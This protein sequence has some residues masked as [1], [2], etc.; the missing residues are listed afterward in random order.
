MDYAKGY[1]A[2]YR[3]MTVDAR[4]WRDVTRIGGV[5]EWKGTKS[6]SSKAAAIDAADLSLDAP[7]QGE[8]YVRTW[9]DAEQDGQVSRVALGT[10]L[11]QSSGGAQG[12]QWSSAELYGVLQPASDRMLPAGWYAPAGTHGPTKAAA[13]L[14]A[15]LDAPVSL[16]SGEG[17]ELAENVVSGGESYLSMAWAL[18]GDAWEIVTDGMGN[19][20]VRPKP[21][22]AAIIREA[23]I[24]GQVETTWKLAGVPNRVTAT[25][26]G[27]TA[28]AIN[29]D[30]DSPASTVARGRIIDG[31]A[32]GDRLSDE[33]LQ[34]F[35]RR[36][37]REQSTA[38]EIAEYTRE[39]RDGIG[40][41]DMVSLPGYE[42]TWRIVSQ[43]IG[44][45]CGA[46]VQETATREVS[47][48]AQ[49]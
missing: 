33:T 30:P 22:E 35:C 32:D 38:T 48:Y 46:T 5:S 8:G 1:A 14:A 11:L 23:D 28:E 49:G 41:G 34:A 43:Q 21:T 9:M 17:G 7:A 40:I 3:L 39:W 37:L 18:C 29:D 31:K 24:I 4:T 6:I 15:T 13:L 16:E 10:Y 42:G 47:T 45:G 2:T 19:V 44:A 25:D 12:G 26:D 27:V 20:A 36:C